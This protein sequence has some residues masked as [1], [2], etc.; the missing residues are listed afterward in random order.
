[1]MI[2]IDQD[3]YV[4][5]ALIL[6][7]SICI[8]KSFLAFLIFIFFNI[9]LIVINF[10]LLFPFLALGR[11]IGPILRCTHFHSTV[12]IQFNC[13][14][15]MSAQPIFKFLIFSEVEKIIF[16]FIYS[17]DLLNYFIFMFI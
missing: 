10:Y 16:S 11:S 5:I 6:L 13:D 15:L 14:L 9:L 12:P 1:M 8:L 17:M 4:P 7:Q 2:E 3:F